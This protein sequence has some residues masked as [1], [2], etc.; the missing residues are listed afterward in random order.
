M[1]E[2]TA[3]EVLAAIRAL[4]EEIRYHTSLALDNF[5]YKTGISPRQIIIN[6]VDVSTNLD[7]AKRY[8]VS[9]VEIDLSGL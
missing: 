7:V 6:M 8:T 9:N 3:T 1:A 4:K 5:S 2:N